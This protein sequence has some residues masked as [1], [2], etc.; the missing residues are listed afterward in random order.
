M[1]KQV[2][3]AGGVVVE[4]LAGNVAAGSR[5]PT[6]AEFDS[7]CSSLPATVMKDVNLPQ[8]RTL[9]ELGGRAK[10]YIIDL[11]TMKIVELHQ[12][13]TTGAGNTAVAVLV[14]RILNLLK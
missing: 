13:T 8:R 14:P 11:R 5:Q 12:G 7:W 1:G 4:M 9:T 10:G 3:T 2:V 6:K